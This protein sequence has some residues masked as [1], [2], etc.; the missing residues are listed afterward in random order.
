MSA[1]RKRTA[2]FWMANSWILCSV[3]ND[4]FERRSRLRNGRLSINDVFQNT[5]IGQVSGKT[6]KALGDDIASKGTN[7]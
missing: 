3:R 2:C 7:T 6:D 4:K 5:E 1:F